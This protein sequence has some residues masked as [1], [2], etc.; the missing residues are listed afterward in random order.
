MCYAIS[1]LPPQSQDLNAS[2]D[3]MQFQDSENV[4]RNL[5]I[6]QILRLHGTK[7]REY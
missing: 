3:W 1:G 5:E 6:A 4:Q 7:L 2:R